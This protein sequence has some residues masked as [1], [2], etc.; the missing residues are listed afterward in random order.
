MQ[1]P[2]TTESRCPI[3]TAIRALTG[4]PNSWQS[5]SILW[6]SFL[7]IFF[8]HIKMGLKKNSLYKKTDLQH[9]QSKNQVSKFYFQQP[10]LN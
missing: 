8:A 4:S 6:L 3:I 5:T 1:L 9:K 10:L 7:F 2:F